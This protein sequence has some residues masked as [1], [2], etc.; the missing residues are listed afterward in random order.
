MKPGESLDRFLIVKKLGHGGM[1]GV[2]IG[3]DPETDSLCAVK[4]L[5]QEYNDDETYVRRF[6]REAEILS[7][8]TH[9]NI[10]QLIDSGVAQGRH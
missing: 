4:V 2:F 5:I 10:I 9:P 7:K 3:F 1:G 6:E 8:L